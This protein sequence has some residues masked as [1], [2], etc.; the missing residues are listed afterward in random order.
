MMRQGADAATAEDLAQETLL[1][2]WR[3]AS[4]YAADKGSA[5]TWI[6]AIARNLRIDRLRREVPWQELPE[7]RLEQGLG[8]R[9]ARRGPGG[10]GARRRGCAPRSP[11]FRPSST[12]WW[13]LSYLEGLS[14]GEIAARL[15]L[16]LGTVKSRMRI[17]YQKIR[18]GAR[19]PAMTITHHLDDA[20]LMSFAAGALPDALS[21]VAAAHVAMCPR[22]RR[23]IGD[24]ERVGGALLAELPPAAI[25]R[26]R[27]PRCRPRNL[28]DGRT[29]SGRARRGDAAAA[30]PASG[31]RS[32][33]HPLALARARRVASPPAAARHRRAAAV[34]GRPGPQRSRARPWRRRADARPARVLPRHHGHVSSAGDVADLDETIEHQPS[35]PRRVHLPG[36]QREA[37]A[38]PRPD[39]PPAA[40]LA[41]HVRQPQKCARS[42][43][44]SRRAT[45]A[46]PSDSSSR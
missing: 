16:P 15:E 31:R 19:G 1:T 34:Q 25:G 40:A 38:L 11:T 17:A 30:R 10:E 13:P 27:P 22:C 9:A 3:R 32:R 26:A 14:H 8:R 12:R 29:A 7:E 41:R 28:R 4:L 6:F 35:R 18:A 2:V 24:L 39:R 43:A 46:P 45:H 44:R 5:A 36:G 21:A 33:R 20:T 37:G 42:R 23:E